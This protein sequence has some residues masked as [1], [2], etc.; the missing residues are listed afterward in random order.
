MSRFGR[1]NEFKQT[2]FMQ[3]TWNFMIF[4][5]FGA[6]Q[7]DRN[8]RTC[9]EFRSGAKRELTQRITEKCI[10]FQLSR[11]KTGTSAAA[12]LVFAYYLPM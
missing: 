4:N 9:P 3:W 8:R 5:T 1:T 2:H 10:D 6:V 12:L 11:C 7:K